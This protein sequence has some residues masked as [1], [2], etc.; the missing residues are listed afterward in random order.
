MSTC[1]NLG[2]LDMADTGETGT[3]KPPRG[4]NGYVSQGYVVAHMSEKLARRKVAGGGARKEVTVSE[5]QMMASLVLRVV[6]E[7]QGC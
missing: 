6:T 3:D 1:R 4:V 7:A 2:T 5:E